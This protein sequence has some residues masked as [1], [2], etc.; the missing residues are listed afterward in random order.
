[1]PKG[2]VNLIDKDLAF[3]LLLKERE[4]VFGREHE[5]DIE[6]YA[7]HDEASEC[8]GIISHMKEYTTVDRPTITVSDIRN[9]YM[10]YANVDFVMKRCKDGR[11]YRKIKDALDDRNDWEVVRIEPRIVVKDMHNTHANIEVILWVNDRGTSLDEEYT[12]VV[13]DW[14]TDKFG[15]NKGGDGMNG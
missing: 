8:A 1:M 11:E 5:S 12:S 15:C 4:E 9:H 10:R 7:R 2:K 3:D 13:A 14:V 6:R